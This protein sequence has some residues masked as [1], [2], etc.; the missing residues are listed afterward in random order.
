MMVLEPTGA[1]RTVVLA[2]P[3]SILT[4]PVTMMAPWGAPLGMKKLPLASVVPTK[5]SVASTVPLLLV[6]M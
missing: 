2:T 5:K 1:L 4:P 3:V 6:S